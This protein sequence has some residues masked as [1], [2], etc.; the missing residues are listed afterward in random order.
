MPSEDGNNIKFVFVCIE[1][2]HRTYVELDTI[3]SFRH[4]QR[5]LEHILHE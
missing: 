1:K 5:I 4:Q 2:K 3:D